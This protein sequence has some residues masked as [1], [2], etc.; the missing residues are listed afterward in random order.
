MEKEL[1]VIKQILSSSA[2]FADADQYGQERIEEM[3]RGIYAVP[4]KRKGRSYEEIYASSRKGK[5]AEFGLERELGA[6]LNPKRWSL[7]DRDSYVWDAMLEGVKFECKQF[8]EKWPSFYMG[9][10][11][12]AIRNLDGFDWFV[13]SNV[14]R[15]YNTFSTVV[16]PTVVAHRECFSKCLAN[17]QKEG[18]KF[19]EPDEVYVKLSKFWNEEK[20]MKVIKWKGLYSYLDFRAI[21]ATPGWEEL[22]WSREDFYG[23]AI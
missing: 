4:A 20:H 21:K 13:F 17:W 3:A 8:A 23:G 14:R 12:T 19:P 9:D 2:V 15:D 1:R 18:T 10:V 7:R 6:T 16:T 5:L 22:I 11:K